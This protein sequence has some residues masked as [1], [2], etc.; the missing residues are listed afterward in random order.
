MERDSGGTVG[1]VF[2]SVAPG[3]DPDKKPEKVPDKPSLS[4]RAFRAICEMLKKERIP[5]TRRNTS[6]YPGS[7]DGSKV[8]KTNGA[9]PNPNE[10]VDELLALK[11]GRKKAPAVARVMF[12][13]GENVAAISAVEKK[14]PSVGGSLLAGSCVSAASHASK[15]SR[16][17]GSRLVAGSIVSASGNSASHCAGSVVGSEKKAAG[18]VIGSQASTCCAS[19]IGPSASQVAATLEKEE[20]KLLREQ[21]ETDEMRRNKAGLGGGGGM[22]HLAHVGCYLEGPKKAEDDRF[23][24]NS[25]INHVIDRLASPKH[26]G[27]CPVGTY[28]RVMRNKRNDIETGSETKMMPPVESPRVVQLAN[29]RRELPFALRSLKAPDT[30]KMVINKKTKQR[31]LVYISDNKGL[32]EPRCSAP[33]SVKKL[34]PR[35]DHPSRVFRIVPAGNLVL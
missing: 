32:V 17:S 24:T 12:L 14:E 11:K 2:R 16:L 9:P 29:Q 10:A 6:D 20:E 27:G 33:F 28:D 23:Y 35:V 34:D 3:S 15:N 21:M 1:A 5:K 4:F 30:K 22:G 7:K 18:S 25:A 8:S 31:L 13:S 19:S 26:I